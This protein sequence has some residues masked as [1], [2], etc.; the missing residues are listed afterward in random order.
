MTVATLTWATQGPSTFTIAGANPTVAE[1]LTK[2][3]SMIASTTWWQVSDYNSSNGTLELKRNSTGSPT[4]EL[5]TVRILIFGGGTPNAA[6]LSLLHTAGATTGLYAGLSVDANTTGPSASYTAGAP[7][8]TKYARAGL[9][10]TPSSTLTTSAVPKITI[11]ESVDSFGFVIADTAGYHSYH[12]GR[13]IVRG[14]DESLVWGNMPSGG[15]WTVGATMASLSTLA[16]GVLAPN[17]NLASNATTGRANY[18]DT[19]TAASRLFGRI[20]AFSTYG[21]A[22]TFLGTN[23]ASGRLKD[24]DL[25]ESL[26]V[27]GSTISFFGELRQV[28]FGPITVHLN[29]LKDNAN[30][31]QGTHLFCTGTTAG[32]GFW[33]DELP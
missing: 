4:G 32:I 2:L 14:S 30:V 22:D 11:F 27:V 13:I 28:R 1:V 25:C 24:I 21:V 3:N 10:C 23:G 17:I 16:Q 15:Q 31:L 18:W 29:K 26:A 33:L 7:Y 6:A 20:N 8:S 9:I 5:A 12:G 19:V